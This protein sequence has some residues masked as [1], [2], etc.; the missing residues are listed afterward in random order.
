MLFF[1][2]SDGFLKIIQK[3]RAV[4]K[5]VKIYF[6]IR[7]ASKSFSL[8]YSDTSGYGL[9]RVTIFIGRE[10]ARVRVAKLA[11]SAGTPRV[12]VTLGQHGNCVRLPA[13][14]FLYLHLAQSYDQLRLWLVGAAILILR[15]AGGVG[16]TK[17]AT[18]TSTPGV[19]PALVCKGHGVG[20]ATCDLHH[21]Y[22]LE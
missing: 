22:C 1:G 19:E 15:H 6:S 20:V 2:Y 14:N 4:N 3:T 18:T 13:G 17:L 10:T 8:T 11:A 9:V 5:R 7:S 16:V 21:F 12:E